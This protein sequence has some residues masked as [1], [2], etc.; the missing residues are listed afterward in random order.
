MSSIDGEEASSK[1]D[2]KDAPSASMSSTRQFRS[3]SKTSCRCRWIW[4]IGNG[5]RRLDSSCT[6]PS[7][8]G[9]F[10]PNSKNIRI[11]KQ[12]DKFT[13]PSIARSPRPPAKRHRAR[14]R[15]Q[16]Q[17]SFSARSILHFHC[18]NDRERLTRLDLISHVHIHAD[19]R[20]A[21]E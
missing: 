7:G 13:L 3:C 19:K 18:L 11:I 9:I 5:F 17:P 14:L 4:L 20:P 8:R 12:K 21:S 2:S 6:G 1:G 15:C 16:Q 10:P